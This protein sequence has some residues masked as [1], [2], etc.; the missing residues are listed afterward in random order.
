MSINGY[1]DDSDKR[2][3]VCLTASA[4]AIGAI[5]HLLAHREHSDA[6]KLT[7]IA[8]YIERLDTAIQLSIALDF[9]YEA[10]TDVA[11]GRDGR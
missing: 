5:S 3:E 2:A 4:F 11:L 7:R 6:E 9:N 10:A 8:A 1:R